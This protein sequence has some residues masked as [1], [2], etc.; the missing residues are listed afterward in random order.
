LINNRGDWKTNLS[1]LVYYGAVQNVIFT[2]LQSAMFAMLFSDDDEDEKKK[3]AIGRIGNGIADTLLRGSGI[4]GAAVSAAK[5]IALEVIDQA[6]GKKDF[7]KAAMEI[8]T[9]SPPI[10]S[11][12][13]KLMSAGRAFKYKQNREKIREL[14][15]ASIENPAY[16]AAAQI[17]SATANIP[18][19][20][21]LRKFE[22]LKASVDSD[23]EMW[24]SIALALGYSKWDVGLI[25]KEREAKKLE[26]A[27]QKSNDILFKELMKPRRRKNIS[28]KQMGLEQLLKESIKEQEKG[29]KK[30]LPEGVLG[31]AYKDGTMQ[32]KPGL[33]KEK[34]KKVVAHEKKHLQDI[35]NGILNYNNNFIFYKGK[36]YK[37][38]PDKKVVYNGKKF[39]EG[40]SK[41][42]WEAAAN[43][44]ERKVS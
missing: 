1:K 27:L 25:E 14:G 28:K 23:T 40:H 39:P 43:K 2:A 35:K 11:K 7:E 34:R 31:R 10:D 12:L 22:N 3:E 18:L 4:A 37:R 17:L 36:Q 33:P 13:S 9:L 5:N 26:D 29:L 41:L 30:E 42:P 38:T 15:P 6:K 19:D 32:I 24:Q 20:R 44:A 21:A 8:T 16:M